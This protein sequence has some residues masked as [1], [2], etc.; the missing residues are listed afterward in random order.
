MSKK[1]VILFISFSSIFPIKAQKLNNQKFFADSLF[2]SE[3]Y[4]DAITEYKRLQFF[5]KKNGKYFESNF[6]I[7]LSYKA[8]GKYDNAIK[9]FNLAK[10][11]AKLLEDSIQIDLQI[12][13][14]NILR[15]TIPEALFLIE[16]FEVKNVGRIDTSLINYWTGW[17][18]L[19]NDD[20][21]SASQEFSKI[22]KF[23]QL[24][25]LSDS[26][27]SAKYSVPLAKFISSV[28][29]GSGQFYTGNYWS[30]VFS[31]AWYL[32]GGYLTINAFLTDRTFEGI[33]M[34][35]LI[36]ARFYRGNLTNAEKFAI[37]ENNKIS[38]NAYKFLME[39]YLGEKP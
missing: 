6:K 35:S 9:Y 14:T 13:R 39:K 33:L 26:V 37:K 21:E 3:N 12:I 30:G 28:L 11:D 31:L 38:N 25:M 16:K 24:K 36:W 23:H 5:S 29:P 8:G 19:V 4:F 18:Y 27:F 17:A 2:A 32:F 1:I 34:G 22:D 15:R 7:A 10:R 20:W